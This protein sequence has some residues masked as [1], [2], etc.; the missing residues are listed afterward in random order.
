[1]LACSFLLA[2]ALISLLRFCITQW[3]DRRAQAPSCGLHATSQGGE[4]PIRRL[5]QHPYLFGL[6]TLYHDFIDLHCHNSTHRA[7]SRHN[8]YGQTYIFTVFGHSTIHTI[9]PAN[10]LAVTTNDFADYEKG[11]WAQ[12]IAKYMGKGVLVNDGKEWNASRTLLKPL[13]RRN[14]AADVRMFERHVDCLIEYLRR[15]EGQFIDCRR[16]AQMVV[17]DITTEMLTGQSAVSFKRSGSEASM[18]DDGHSMRG[19]A[20]LDLIDELEPYGNMGIELGLFA[21]PV[22]ALRY[23]KI[24]SLIKGIQRFFETAISDINADMRRRHRDE[25]NCERNNII[26][27]M[28]AQGLA[29][30]Q[31]QGELQNIFFAAFDTT[32]ALLT[33]V[34]D[35]A[36][37][38]PDLI[39]R[40]QVECTAVV[41]SRLVDEADITCMP[42]LRATI[43]ETLRL[44]SPITYHTRKARTDTRLPRGGGTDGHSPVFLPRGTS[45]TWSTYA[46]NR[47]A[48]AYGDDWAAFK[49]DRWLRDDGKTVASTETFMPFG[50]GPRNCLGQQFAMLQVTY[51]AA[52]LLTAFEH[53][54]LREWAVLF[55]EAA[56]VT[57]Y[58]GQ[59]TWIKFR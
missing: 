41:G 39:K 58:N 53:F 47:Q 16:T 7:L 44:H 57:H 21:L 23:R 34:F 42:L 6:D 13:F 4:R 49:P 38:Q 35:C 11:D 51:I 12:T 54:E 37:R 1:M 5:S 20:L 29:P 28:L 56:A 48:W 3:M 40:L 43:F 22:F 32:T 17:L 9:D 2:L 26:E 25:Q 18:E 46:I 30:A 14:R 55:Q 59:G 45:V 50:S 31:V 15:R 27:E 19:P 24:M 33:N 8:A 52:R 36:T 10:I